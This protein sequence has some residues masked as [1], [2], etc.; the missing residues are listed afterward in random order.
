MGHGPDMAGQREASVVRR[1]PR[2]GARRSPLCRRVC[3]YLTECCGL[4]ARARSAGGQLACLQAGSNGPSEV[5]VRC[6]LLIFVWDGLCVWV[7]RR[8]QRWC[9]CSMQGGARSQHHTVQGKTRVRPA[10]RLRATAQTW[11]GRGRGWSGR[12]RRREGPGA[13]RSAST[14]RQPLLD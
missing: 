7:A 14:A 5:D 1:E 13:A 9:E 6:A 10:R 8:C 4:C 2:R 3:R 11:Q 12:G